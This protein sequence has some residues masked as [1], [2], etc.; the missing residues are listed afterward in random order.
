MPRTLLLCCTSTRVVRHAYAQHDYPLRTGRD[1]GGRA[2][3]ELLLDGYKLR[4][5]WEEQPQREH[6]AELRGASACAPL[7][8]GWPPVARA[9]RCGQLQELVPAV[10]RPVPLS[11]IY[12]LSPLTMGP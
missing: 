2:L 11:S 9:A 7:W 12:C 10:N 5:A 8:R 6:A 3:S 1:E 4:R